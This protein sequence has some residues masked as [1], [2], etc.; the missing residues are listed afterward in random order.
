MSDRAPP[1]IVPP[2]SWQPAAGSQQPAAVT[3]DSVSPSPCTAAPSPISG[4]IP[5]D[6]GGASACGAQI[7]RT[8]S[9]SGISASSRRSAPPPTADLTRSL[10]TTPPARQT[11]GI[12]ARQAATPTRSQP[13]PDHRCTKRLFWAIL[14]LKWSFDQDRLGTN[15]GKALKKETRFSQGVLVNCASGEYSKSVLPHLKGRVQVTLLG[16]PRS[17]RRRVC[18]QLPRGSRRPQ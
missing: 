18:L 1:A 7:T 4:P 16:R 9:A 2:S 3:V 13:A 10:G 5:D 14:K 15:I 8:R 11:I 6:L 12:T 17:Q